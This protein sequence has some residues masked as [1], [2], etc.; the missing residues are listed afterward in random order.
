LKLPVIPSVDVTRIVNNDLLPRYSCDYNYTTVLPSSGRWWFH[1]YCWLF[2]P[3]WLPLYNLPP[4][5]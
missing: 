1:S 4:A 2:S 5:Q 3:D